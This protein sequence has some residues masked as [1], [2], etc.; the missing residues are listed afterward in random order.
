MKKLQEKMLKTFSK[1]ANRMAEQEP[2]EWP[3]KCYL[4][5]YQPVRPYHVKENEAHKESK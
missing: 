1:A 5:T 2:R 3:P 4:L